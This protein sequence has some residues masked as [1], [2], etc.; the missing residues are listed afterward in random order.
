MRVSLGWINTMTPGSGWAPDSSAP[1]P[2][3]LAP[4]TGGDPPPFLLG[5]IADMSSNLVPGT[6]TGGTDIKLS[7]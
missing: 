3:R 7:A 4:Q 2:V 6:C 5:L 1:Q